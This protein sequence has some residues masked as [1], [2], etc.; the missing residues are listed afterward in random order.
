MTRPLRITSCV[1]VGR[2]SLLGTVDIEFGIQ[3]LHNCA[4][5]R[6]A[7][8]GVFVG[9]PRIPKIGRDGKQLRSPDGK[10]VFDPAVEWIDSAVNNRFQ[11]AVLEIIRR[12]FPALLVLE[13]EEQLALPPASESP[14]AR[15]RALRPYARQARPKANGNGSSSG[16]ELN[17][18][19][20]DLWQ[21]EG[22]EP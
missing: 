11:T 17:D 1:I 3:R 21:P 5:M 19:I 7:R 10:G 4:V 2:G 12:D 20:S 18:D 9:L 6:T 13:A 8:G 14:P 15:T 22:D 16:P